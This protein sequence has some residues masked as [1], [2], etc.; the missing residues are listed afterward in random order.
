MALTKMVDTPAQL[1]PSVSVKIWS[2]T[3]AAASAGTANRLSAALI[4][5]VKGFLAWVSSR[6]ENRRQ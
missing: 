2:P 5:L 4:P 3:R 6:L 1:P